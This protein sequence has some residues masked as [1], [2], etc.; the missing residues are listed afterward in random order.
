MAKKTAKKS[1]TKKTT[2]KKTA[3]KTTTSKKT[4]TKKTTKKAATKK[5]TKKTAKKA[6]TTKKT[7]KKTAKAAAEQAPESKAKTAEA[8]KPAEDAKSGRKGITVVDKKP[9][10]RPRQAPKLTM[11]E[12]GGSLLG[13]LKQGPLIPSGPDAPKSVYSSLP[14]ID[15][16]RKQ[17]ST[18][19][20]SGLKAADLQSFKETLIEKRRELIGDVSKLE[21]G[22]LEVV[23]SDRGAFDAAEQGSDA[24][25][26]SLSLGLAAV[27]RRLIKEI[28]DALDRIENGTFG[29]CEITGEPIKMTRLRELPWTRYSIEG[30]R[31]A[32]SGGPR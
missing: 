30:A 9:A 7:T 14:G 3:A 19:R 21:K 18:A 8:S 10:R 23:D 11:P 5:T 27:D 28:D 32:E 29:I 25:D 2:A 22:A 16:G 24:Y 6:E 13:K 4:T 1:V 31:L 15:D 20:K 26:Q 17:K 12:V